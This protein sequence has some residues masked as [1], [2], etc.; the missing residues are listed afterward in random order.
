MKVDQ[1]YNKR[2]KK[3]YNLLVEILLIVGIIALLGAYG[4]PNYIRAKTR[5]QTMRCISNLMDI[6]DA[7][8]NWAE[9]NN[10]K[11]EDPVNMKELVPDYLEEEPFCPLDTERRGYILTVVGADPHCPM[12]ALYPKHTLDYKE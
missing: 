7:I 8:K 1:D 10:K 4:I 2:G 3:E 5:T 6:K 12:K 11:D 9:D